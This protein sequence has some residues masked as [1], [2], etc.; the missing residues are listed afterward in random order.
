[1]EHLEGLLHLVDNEIGAIVANGKFRSREEL[2]N[3]YKLVDIAKDIY[4]TWNYENEDSEYSNDGRYYGDDRHMTR[5]GD[6]SYRGRNRDRMG[7]YSREM[8][9]RDS[10]Q[11]YI[12]NLRDMMNRA[13]DDQTRMSIQRMIDEMEHR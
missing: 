3:A 11:Q 12:E 6:M 1:M 5:R 8:Y 9:S 4:C 2:E 10:K 7:R 13:P